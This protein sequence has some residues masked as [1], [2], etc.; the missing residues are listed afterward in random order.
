M[1]AWKRLS[2]TTLAFALAALAGFSG[3]AYHIPLAW[4]LGPLL[5]AACL[6]AAGFDLRP[7]ENVRKFGQLTIG[8]AVGLTM[9]ASVLAELGGWLPLMVLSALV[10]VMMSC[11]AG[12]ILARQAR[13]D[14]KTAFFASLPGGLAEM[15][16]IG[17]QMGAQ[18][19]P[20]AI[21]HTLR[22]TIVALTI[23]SILL[24]F[25]TPDFA[26]APGTR[27]VDPYWTVGLIVGGAAFAY[28]LGRIRLNNPY[29]IGAILFTAIFA[30]RGLV[31]G[32]M[33]HPLFAVAQ[34][35]IGF[36]VGCRFRRDILAKLPRVA[37][38]SVISIF[39]LGTVMV[40]FA[41]LL[42]FAT[43]LTYPAA[44]LASSPG[45]L[46]E[47]TVTAEILHLAVPTVVGFQV[48]RGILVNSL[49]SHYYA[50]LTRYGVL[51]LLQRVFGSPD[52][53]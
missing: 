7:N 9:T 31:A 26:V 38:F 4:M 23:P 16:N 44:I 42:S 45:G 1:K 20:I 22:V 13:L 46:S 35:M 47:M 49:A 12:V 18:A 11:V 15:G 29:M 37:F 34:L 10:S 30:S 8:T 33:Y 48:V 5:V 6:S 17:V 36:A 32:K 14:Q 28:F 53:G 24:A 41:L 50:L 52:P 39:G 2:T 51:D 27:I 3:A 25:G 40:G 19:E 21:V 43:G